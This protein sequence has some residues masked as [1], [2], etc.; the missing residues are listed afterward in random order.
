MCAATP[1][2]AFSIDASCVSLTC[3]QLPQ[4][5]RHVLDAAHPL[6]L[7]PFSSAWCMVCRNECTSW[8]YRCGICAIH[9]ECLLTPGDHA[10]R[11][12]SSSSTTR[13]R[14]VRQPAAPPAFGAHYANY[15]YGVPSFSN[16]VHNY[17]YPYQAPSL[18]AYNYA[19][20]VPCGFG[21]YNSVM[22]H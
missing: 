17:A 3:T 18:G 4:Q 6:T 2:K 8:R 11:S 13:S 12:T 10:S 7:Q 5:V 1:S 15:N 20:G 9:L 14:S 21:P 19:Y 22:S 16:G